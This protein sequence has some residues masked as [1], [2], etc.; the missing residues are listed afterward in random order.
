MVYKTLTALVLSLSLGCGAQNKYL[1]KSYLER[2]TT[3]C[4]QKYDVREECQPNHSAYRK[5]NSTRENAIDYLT[6]N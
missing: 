1:V 5:N 6:I 4:E 3:S 2:L